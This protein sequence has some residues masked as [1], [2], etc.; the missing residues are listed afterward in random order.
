MIYNKKY[1]D[2]AEILIVDD[3]EINRLVL[4]EI[5]HSMGCEPILA[6]NGQQALDIAKEKKPKLI[7]TDISMPDMDGY[8][9]CKALKSNKKTKDIPVIFISAYDDSTDIVAGFKLG[10]EDYITKPFVPEI[11]QV[12]VG[13]HLNLYEARNEVLEM[14]RRLQISV[15]EQLKQ[16]EE[17]KKNILY[18]LANMATKN[19]HYEQ[20]HMD[21]LKYNCRMLAQGMQLSPLFEDKISD[22]Y[23]DTI[24]LAAPLFDI[25][26][27]GIPKEILQKKTGLTEE[28]T[29]IIQSHAEMGAQLLKDLHVNNDYNDFIRISIDVAHYH[30]EHWDGSG[31]PC[32]LKQNEIPLAAQ[33]VAIMDAYC[34]LTGSKGD[35]REQALEEMGRD[36]GVKY[37][38]DIYEI[39]CKI[40][41]QLS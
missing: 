4:E 20:G 8:E 1:K 33:I 7:L 29:A 18:A 16:M 39:C 40:S 26:K 27:L 34:T 28:E 2:G 38:P 9:L 30:H 25:G 15:S 23:I 5:I 22:V 17:E 11:V 35:G 31:Y 6:E 41:R 37:N 12:R 10:G 19:S 14:N 21:R 13:V 24:E 3:V 36:A 32:G